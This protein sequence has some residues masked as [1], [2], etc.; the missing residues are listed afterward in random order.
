MAKQLTP[1]GRIL[2]IVAGLSLVGYGLYK[3]E[4]FDKIIPKA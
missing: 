1:L 3:Y 2:L 4:V